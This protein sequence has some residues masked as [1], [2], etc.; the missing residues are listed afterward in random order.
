V[1]VR[2]GDDSGFVCER[3]WLL[4]QPARALPE[5]KNPATFARA[6]GIRSASASYPGRPD[7]YAALRSHEFDAHD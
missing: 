3:D 1:T 5:M 2:G 6:N 7:L 4:Q